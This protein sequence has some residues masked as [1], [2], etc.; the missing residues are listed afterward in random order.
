MFRVSSLS[1]C[2]RSALVLCALYHNI[3]IP[4]YP[5]FLVVRALKLPYVV[6]TLCIHR[7]SNFIGI[8]SSVVLRFSLSACFFCSCGC[9]LRPLW[10]GGLLRSSECPCFP[11]RLVGPLAVPFR[12]PLFLRCSQ[13]LSPLSLVLGFLRHVGHAG[14]GNNLLACIGTENFDYSSSFAL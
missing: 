1:A 7:A 5:T 12:A 6:L 8:S 4:D 10:P 14:A 3:Y 2:V 13:A 9:F 11:C